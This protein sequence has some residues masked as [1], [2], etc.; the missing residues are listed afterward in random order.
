M[1]LNVIK[2][3]SVHPGS[4]G[5]PP[6]ALVGVGQHIRSIHLVLQQVK[7][8]ARTPLRFVMLRRLEFP[9]LF[10]RFQTHRQSPAFSPSDAPLE[11]RPLRSTGITRLP[12]YYEPLRLPMWPSLSLTGRRLEFAPHRFGSLVL[13]G[14]PLRACRRPSLRQDG[15][16]LSS[17]RLTPSAFPFRAAGRLL[18]SPFSELSRR[19]LRLRPTRALSRLH[20]PLTP[21]AFYGFVTASTTQAASRCYDQLPGGD[22]TH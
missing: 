2:R 6:A 3:L 5:I 14:L 11:L 20:D 21:E 8:I 9:N 13:L 17:S 22:H 16:V 18:Q 10:W 15:K 1:L 12:H 7:P 4:P 19:S